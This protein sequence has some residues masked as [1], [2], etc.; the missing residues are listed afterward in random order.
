LESEYEEC[1]VHSKAPEE[2]KLVSIFC[3]DIYVF[4]IAFVESAVQYP[5]SRA[6]S[7]QS[8]VHDRRVYRSTTVWL[9]GGQEEK[10][11]LRP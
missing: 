4:D 7:L 9:R 10:P 3:V 1:Y 8:N 6:K 11:K 5:L 2:R